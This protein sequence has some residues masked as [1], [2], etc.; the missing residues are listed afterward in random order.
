MYIYY[1]LYSLAS[2]FFLFWGIRHAKSKFPVGLIGFWLLSQPILQR[3]EFMISTPWGFDL[4]PARIAFLLILIYFFMVGRKVFKNL[5]TH[6]MALKFHEWMLLVFTTIVV[7]SLAISSL[8]LQDQIVQAAGFLVFICFYF[9]SRQTLKEKDVKIVLRI[10]IYY[11]IISVFVAIVQFFYLPEFFRIS[12]NRVAFGEYYRANGLFSNE[13]ELG[14]YL[15]YISAIIL[16]WYKSVPAKFLI[17]GFLSIGVA[18][19]MHRGSWIVFTTGILFYYF[20]SWYYFNKT[21]KNTI[22]FIFLISIFTITV[23]SGLAINFPIWNI[24][25]GF[26]YDRLYQDTLTGRKDLLGLGIY[27]VSQYPLG[28]GDY[29]TEE[30]WKLYSQYGLNYVNRSSQG[31]QIPLIVH[32]GFLSSAVRFGILGG[33]AFTVFTI[34]SALYFLRNG[35]LKPGFRFVQ[36]SI[37]IAFIL[38]NISQDFSELGISSSLVFA[39]LSGISMKTVMEGKI[40]E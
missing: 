14:I 5:A 24:Q 22:T 17:V 26:I 2:L 32:N 15:T 36:L 1:I 29:H 12:S 7:F 38:I 23:M 28:I 39:V 16:Y 30:Y 31:L 13:Y 11:A 20:V 34:A 18:L 21:Q 8:S 27:M 19:T 33:V 9:L 4:Q 6:R 10:F 35:G 25:D 3:P 37:C 40:V